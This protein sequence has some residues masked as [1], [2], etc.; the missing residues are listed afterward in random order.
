[1]DT[2]QKKTTST[3]WV[4]ALVAG[5]AYG[6]VIRV[7]F[8]GEG[9]SLFQIV[10]TAFLVVAPFCVGAISVLV[11]AGRNPIPV[12]RQLSVSA[13]SMSLF[14]VAMFISL[15]EGLICLVVVA[16]VFY[17]AALVGGLLAGWI[18]N[19]F[20]TS[21][22]TLPAFA[23]LPLLFGPLE[24]MLPAQTSIQV[25]S[26][27]V[28]VSAPPAQVFDQLAHVR[29]I[30]PGELGFSLLH[31]IGLPRPTEAA[32]QGQGAGS[33]R[34]SRWEKGVQFKE[35]ITVWDRPH[36]MHYRFDI[37]PG[38]IPREALDRHVELGG[39][40]FTVLDGGYD[41]R[42]AAGG[43]PELTLTTR[44]LNKS[45]LKLYGDVWGKLVLADFHHAIL[46]LMKSRSEAAGNSG[47]AAN[48]G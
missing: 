26:S 12:G 28:H 2:P 22:A 47:Q 13:L 24:S 25:V 39:D 21:R 32:M 34:T 45:R 40:Y 35:V 37:P 7:G 43:G 19:R 4:Q 8:E 44:F 3:L 10:S 41:L 11:A 16:P 46:G 38:S 15:L 6:L 31:V 48:A 27:S 33:V 42:P 5:A 30:R 17:V 14:L 20:R 29:D 9:Q 23:L 1:M 36:A 18:N